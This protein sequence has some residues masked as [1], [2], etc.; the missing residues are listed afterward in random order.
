M[1]NYVN[2]ICLSHTLCVNGMFYYYANMDLAIKPDYK[3]AHKSPAIKI[4]TRYCVF[5]VADFIVVVFFPSSVLGRD[6]R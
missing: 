6:N 5:Y 3:H 4:E 1:F 2:M